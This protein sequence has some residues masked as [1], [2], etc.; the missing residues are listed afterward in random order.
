MNLSKCPYCGVKLGNYR[1]ADACP[2]CHKQLQHRIKQPVRISM[3]RSPKANSPLGRMFLS[4]R[5]WVELCGSG[6]V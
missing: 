5:N 4:V 3:R 2:K 6:A 1:Y